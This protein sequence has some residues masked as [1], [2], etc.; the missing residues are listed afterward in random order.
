MQA[1]KDPH[2]MRLGQIVGGCTS[3]FTILREQKIEDAISPPARIRVLIPDLTPI[4][5]LEVEIVRLKFASERLEMEQKYLRLQE[6]AD[7]AESNARVH[8][9][10]AQKMADVYAKT[11]S[12]N[13]NLYIVNKKL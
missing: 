1:W 3:K 12:E 2:R 5:S 13:E 6:M 10:K 11:K 4:Q 8:E 9:R 7:K